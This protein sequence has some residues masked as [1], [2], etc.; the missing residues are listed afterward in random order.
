MQA[1][2]EERVVEPRVQVV[3]LPGLWPRMG[4]T[5]VREGDDVGTG[6]PGSADGQAMKSMGSPMLRPDD[7]RLGLGL[8][9]SQSMQIP[10]ANGGG[11]GGSGRD[12]DVSAGMRW[13]AGGVGRELEGL[14]SGDIGRVSMPGALPA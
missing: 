14:D 8:G 9:R 10:L 6:R 12:E 2:F 13:R 5:R 1:W 7:A 11:L 3:G 4:K